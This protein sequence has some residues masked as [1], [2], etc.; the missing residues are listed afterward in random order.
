MTAGQLVTT[1]LNNL[2]TVAA[3]TVA[4]AVRQ[5]PD[6]R[7]A[8]MVGLTA[9]ALG[10]SRSFTDSSKYVFP[11]AA[12]Y[13]LLAGGRAY[14]NYAAGT[15]GYQ[16]VGNRDYYLGRVIGDALNGDTTC[17]VDINVDPRY[18][19]ELIRDP[20]TTAPIGTQAAGGFGTP[21]RDG[22]ALD[23]LLS[24]TNEAQ[25]V[26]ALSVDTFS[27]SA[28]AIVEFA[29]RVVNNGAGAAAVVNLGIAS[30]THATNA[31][32]ITDRLFLLINENSTK[33]WLQSADGTTTVAATDT[34]LTFAV[35]AALA[36]RVEVWLDLRDPTNVKCYI[37]GVQVLANLVFRVDAAA[38]EFHLLAHM[39]KTASTDTSELALDW[40]RARFQ[41]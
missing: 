8:V 30:G 2:I 23:L 36:Q 4:G 3:A 41:E 38:N 40:M 25:K 18:D 12:G 9:S 39:V 1:R 27:K 31:S 14:F 6:G 21:R 13:N 15:V 24:A 35:G 17:V 11:K 32:A 34:T 19:I 33:L 16:K 22:G 26:D 7:A 10:D 37:N 5:L 28:R 29:F 20:Y